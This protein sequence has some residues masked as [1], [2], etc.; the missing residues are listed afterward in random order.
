MRARFAFRA[1]VAIGIT[2][3][4]PVAT[5]SAVAEPDAHPPVAAQ[6]APQDPL[7]SRILIRIGRGS[8]RGDASREDWKAIV[9]YY[10]E[11]HGAPLWV[12]GGGF[13]KGGE[14]AVAENS[15]GR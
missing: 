9:S 4:V 12:T 14:Q 3:I 1:I 5:R 2:A 7:S 10:S 15:T 13:S 11:R 6:P 8:P